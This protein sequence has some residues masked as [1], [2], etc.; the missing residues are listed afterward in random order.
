MGAMADRVVPMAAMVDIRVSI[1]KIMA[2][3]LLEVAMAVPR[4]ILGDWE[5]MGIILMASLRL[6]SI[7]AR[8]KKKKLLLHRLTEL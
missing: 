1:A 7:K 8:K 4:T 6:I 2:I 3:N 5:F